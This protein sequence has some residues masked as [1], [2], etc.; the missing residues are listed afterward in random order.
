MT[1]N[2]PVNFVRKD[3]SAKKECASF[4]D[5]RK[6]ASEE[7]HIPVTDIVMTDLKKGDLI[8]DTFKLIKP[9]S[10]EVWT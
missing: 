5:M 1:L 10:V 7:F 6:F 3:D 2:F 4:A 9:F 8:E